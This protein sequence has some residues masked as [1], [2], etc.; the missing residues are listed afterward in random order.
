MFFLLSDSFSLVSGNNICFTKTDLV[1]NNIL[2]KVK[3]FF[4]KSFNMMEN[5]D[6]KSVNIRLMQYNIGAFNY[7]SKVS[8]GLSA[9]KYAKKLVA[10]KTMLCKY[11]PD[12]IGVQEIT[13]YID[14]AHKHLTNG[15]LFDPIYPYKYDFLSGE[16]AIKS[17]FPVT[18]IGITTISTVVNGKTYSSRFLRSKVYVGN[19]EVDI[20]TCALPSETNLDYKQARADIF[21][22]MLALLADAEY[23]FIIL[24]MNCGGTVRDDYSSVEEAEELLA[25][26][27]ANG[28]NFAN[29]GYLPWQDTYHHPTWTNRFLPI[30]N[31]IYKDNGKVVFNNFQVL[32]EELENLTSDHYPVFAD[33]LL[34]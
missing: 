31:I 10:Y 13:K 23:G 30:D 9:E 14:A 17:K 21:P 7:G 1:N 25:V 8:P 2:T 32:Y 12:I 27:K 34:L 6:T 16:R 28:F 5:Y 22:Q 18:P 26:A 19:K 20:I 4:T 15:V 11:Q 33:F 24:D 3:H 29:G